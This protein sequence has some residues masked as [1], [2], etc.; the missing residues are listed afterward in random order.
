M[1]KFLANIKQHIQSVAILR[2][3]HDL[4]YQF[5]QGAPF[6]YTLDRQQHPNEQMQNDYNKL[7][8]AYKY[9]SVLDKGTPFSILLADPS[10]IKHLKINGRRFD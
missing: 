2:N 8:P 1:S 4:L 6:L 3:N 5:H 9:P 10:Y 7:H